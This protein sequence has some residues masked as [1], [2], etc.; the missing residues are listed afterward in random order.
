[1]ACEAKARGTALALGEIEY[2]VRQQA[3]GGVIARRQKRCAKSR[4]PVTTSWARLPLFSARS[5]A[6]SAAAR[7]SGA[8]EP[9]R[10]QQHLSERARQL[11]LARVTLRRFGQ[12]L[13][14]LETL[15]Q[16]RLRLGEGRAIQRLLAGA[17][18]IL[19]PP[20]RDWRCGRNDARVRPDGRRAE[21]A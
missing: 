11:Q 5:R 17:R 12:F 3:G 15:L 19:A 8:A 6:R 9:S 21:L 10:D 7:V 18:Q 1:M 4:R 13:D 14:P 2:P 20:C 16:L